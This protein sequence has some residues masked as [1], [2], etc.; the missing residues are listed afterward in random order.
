MINQ[1]MDFYHELIGVPCDPHC[2]DI[3]RLCF[4]SADEN[5]YFN[6]NSEVFFPIISNQETENNFLNDQSPRTIDYCIEFT[7]KVS[8]YVVGSRNAYIYLVARNANRFG[9][10]QDDILNYCLNSFDL[11][12]REIK[13][14]VNSAYKHNVAEFAKFAN[15]ANNKVA[16]ENKQDVLS[17]V[18]KQTPIIPNSVY[19]NL[20]KLLKE[21]IEII[22]EPR[23]R[24][25]FLLSSIAILSGCLPNV[26]GLYFNEPIYTNLFTFILAPPASGK[27]YMKYA[28]MLGNK[29]QK[30][31]LETS[32][33][34]Q[35]EFKKEIEEYKQQKIKK[36]KNQS[37]EL[38]E[39]PKEPP[40]KIFYIPA[41]S[42]S[43]KLYQHLEHNEGRGVICETEA[44]TLGQVFK[45]DW[46]SYSEILRSAY[47]HESISISRKTDN[48]YF[49]IEHPKI[50]I[51][52]TGTPNQILNIMKSA[53]DGLFSRFSFYTFSTPPIWKSPKPVEGKPNLIQFFQDKA[54]KVYDIFQY[55]TNHDTDVELSSNQWEKMNSFF[56][57]TIEES[58][59][60]ISSEATSIVKRHG[61]MLFRFCLILSALRKL[62]Y[63]DDAR[64]ITCEDQD[65][66]SAL[67]IIQTVF[68]HSIMIYS[69][70]P[71]VT[72]EF[73]ITKLSR[74][75][76]LLHN[77][78]QQFQRKEAIEIGKK[79]S[80][81]ERT[82]D[83]LLTKKWLNKHIRKVDTG[84]Y[85]KI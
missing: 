1:L 45:N 6:E 79:L 70:L 39:E 59:D 76:Q 69:N 68:Q 32:K 84:K 15:I 35:T 21:C 12:D 10:L 41:N 37:I 4:M 23:E 29:I 14:S 77:L 8:Q 47:H 50:S 62:E 42:S 7:E 58:N 30:E 52:L 81:S 25:V 19:E 51:V 48:Q 43:A 73:K 46:G 28:K 20:P 56:Q 61:I 66:E 53:E 17:D 72:N 16:N 26:T 3:A 5:V 44:D 13:A 36:N 31:M 85:E 64:K 24:D 60:L 75:D 71:G 55:Y 34:K 38:P 49:Q 22:D 54:E 67:S 57:M 40:F 78:P 33:S 2:K 9:I 27:G 18:L 74:K 83:D 82:I 80:L 65:F 63:G 11:N